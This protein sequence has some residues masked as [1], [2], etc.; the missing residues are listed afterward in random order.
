MKNFFDRLK[1]FFVRYVG[2]T[3]WVIIL[4][5]V[6]TCQYR[7]IE[8]RADVREIFMERYEKDTMSFIS[9]HDF[10]NI[11]FHHI[12]DN[13][14][15]LPL[16]I[17]KQEFWN[18]SKKY[19]LTMPVQFGLDL[20][21]NNIDAL[22]TED[23]KIQYILAEDES[24]SYGGGVIY[25]VACEKDLREELKD[26]RKYIREIDENKYRYRY[27]PEIVFYASVKSHGNFESWRGVHGYTIDFSCND[28]IISNQNY[29]KNKLNW[30]DD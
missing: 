3:P 24:F 13:E 12:E 21:R 2:W 30:V 22:R 26:M 25:K 27:R 28:M 19:V 5:A 10:S 7:D 16:T 20:H 15:D 14:R 18:P 6:T 1:S 8:Q 4:I 29:I 17:D 11:I 23:G 9:S